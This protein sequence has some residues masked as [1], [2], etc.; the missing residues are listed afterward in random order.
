M[1]TFTQPKIKM[2][3]YHNLPTRLHTVQKSRYYWSICMML[4]EP[5]TFLVP[6]TLLPEP[7][8]GYSIPIFLYF[9]LVN[10]NHALSVKNRTSIS[11]LSISAMMSY[12]SKVK[13]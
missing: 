4:E 6:Y 5:F 9:V 1:S 13:P 3:R 11:Q 7:D 2:V 10:T 12:S 8:L